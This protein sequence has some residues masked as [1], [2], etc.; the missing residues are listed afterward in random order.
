MAGGPAGLDNIGLDDPG[1]PS[2]RMGYIGLADLHAGL[3]SLVRPAMAGH[4]LGAARIVG[5]DCLRRRWL[6]GVGLDIR[7]FPLFVLVH[8]AI[9]DSLS[10]DPYVE[11][12]V[13]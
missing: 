4:G 7:E 12:Q 3:E 9:S 13:G 2:M 11:R 6:D 1:R 10:E 8:A 5:L